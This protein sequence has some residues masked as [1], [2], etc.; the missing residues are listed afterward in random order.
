MQELRILT[1]QE[2]GPVQA[3]ELQVVAKKTLLTKRKIKRVPELVQEQ[4]LQVLAM[5][6]EQDLALQVAAQDLL[7]T[8]QEQVRVQPD[9]ELVAAKETQQ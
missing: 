5:E 4:V 7:V 2:R 1:T 9:R 8:E 6:Q 3:W